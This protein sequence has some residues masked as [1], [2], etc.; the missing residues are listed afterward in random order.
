MTL[1]LKL[2]LSALGVCLLAVGLSAGFMIHLF[3][4]EL[5]DLGENSAIKKAH[6]LADFLQQQSDQVLGPDTY[7]KFLEPDWISSMLIDQNGK[8]VISEGGARP[9]QD[10]SNL[11]AD[12]FN[13]LNGNPASEG[14]LSEQASNEIIA[15]SYVP[16]MKNFVITKIRA[17]QTFRLRYFLIFK[18]VLIFLAIACLIWILSRLTANN[19]THRLNLLKNGMNQYGKGELKARIEMSEQ[20]ELGQV[21]SQFNAMANQLD[22]YLSQEKEKVRMAQELQTAKRVQ[23]YFFPALDFKEKSF[24]IAGYYDPAAECGGDWWFYHWKNDKLYLLIGDV[25]GHGTS[26]AML[27]SSCRSAIS[28]ILNS[29]QATEPSAILQTLNSA[30]FDT[31]QGDLNMTMIVFEIDFAKQKFRYSNASHEMPLKWDLQKSDLKKKD[32]DFYLDVNGPRLGESKDSVFT[33]TEI[34]SPQGLRLFLFTDGLYDLENS[35]GQNLGERGL[36]SLLAKVQSAKTTST[37]RDHLVKQIQTYVGNN[38][39]KDDVSFLFVDF[40]NTTSQ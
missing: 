3:G 29:E 12:L 7:R 15:F 6:D 8:S 35:E 28:V 34:E 33:Q 9:D 32:F 5:R 31:V 20:D 13:R 39:L 22:E 37:A 4:K 24:A 27:T 23:K 40:S 1:R 14:I 21:A 16:K 10:S 19:F 11:A 26:S 17:D 38:P 36:L 18:L 25:T 30:I 2:F